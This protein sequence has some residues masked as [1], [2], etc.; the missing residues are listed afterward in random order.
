MCFFHA[1]KYTR[2]PCSLKAGIS[3]ADRLLR[4]GCSLA[5]GCPHL[6]KY[7]PAHRQET[8]RCNCRCPWVIE[9]VPYRHLSF[10]PS[11]SPAKNGVQ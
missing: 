11:T 3:V 1:A 6:S 4:F 2:M 9:R 5:D 8:E 10:V 7:S